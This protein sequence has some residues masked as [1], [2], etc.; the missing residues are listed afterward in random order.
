[1][2]FKI[3]NKDGVKLLTAKTY[4]KED[5]NIT[6]DES[7]LGVDTSDA[8]A[9]ADDIVLGK[10]AYVNNEK[11]E[12]TIG[13]YK[14]EFIFI[15]I[16]E[17]E[18]LPNGFSKLTFIESTGEQY[19]DTEYNMTT[20]SEI[21]LV[22]SVTAYNTSAKMG[23]LGSYETSSTLY[24]LYASGTN[25][26]YFYVSFGGKNYAQT[27]LFATGI[28][29]EIVMKANT[30][31]INSIVYNFTSDGLADATKPLYLFWRNATGAKA[32][33]RLFSCNIYDK[34]ILERKFIPCLRTSDNAVGLYDLAKNKFY[35][36]KGTGAFTGG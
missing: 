17:E 3:K 22:M 10:T 7:L 12:G 16:N 4:C 20:T 30:V 9:T 23:F 25:N 8:T 27:N 5:I 13:T 2:E 29:Y 21:E 32:Q 19:I 26:S 6:F 14:G 28:Q 35:E 18:A 33:M 34:G 36:N 24:Q 1:M 31:S 15:D 11:I